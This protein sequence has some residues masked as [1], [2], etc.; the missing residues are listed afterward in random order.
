MTLAAAAQ[1]DRAL[2]AGKRQDVPRS[3]HAATWLLASGGVRIKLADKHG[4]PTQHGLRYQQL[5]GLPVARRRCCPPAGRPPQAGK[6]AW[7]G[8]GK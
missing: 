6:V 4:V 1:L 2:L 8:I 3:R 5:T 7:R